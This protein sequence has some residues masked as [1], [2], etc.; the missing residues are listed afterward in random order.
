[1]LKM[2]VAARSY[3]KIFWI[4]PTAKREDK[5]TG[6]VDYCRRRD[7]EVKIF[8][9]YSDAEFRELQDWMGGE[10]D[11]YKKYM[12]NLQ[13]W[14]R[15]VRTRSTDSLSFDDL[16]ALDQMDWKRPTSSYKHYPSFCLVL[17]DCAGKR[18]IFASNCKNV[19]S[20]FLILHRHLSCSVLTL[21]QIVGNG[22]P[23]QIRSNISMWMLFACKSATLK[24]AVSEELAFKL[25]ADTLMK[26]WDYC[27]QSGNGHDFVMLDYDEPD[28]GRMIRKNFTHFLSVDSDASDASEKLSES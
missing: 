2:Y 11:E 25:D 3:D 26:A 1:M 15:F 12:K 23:R 8:D 10:I 17:D 21:M 6:F 19:M 7:V 14:N 22:I 20:N 5:M 16:I 13:V 24:K 28:R 4:S 18:D 9:T 27:T